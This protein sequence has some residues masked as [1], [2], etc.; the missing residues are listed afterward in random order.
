MYGFVCVFKC[1]SINISNGYGYVRKKCVYMGICVLRNHL[2]PQ[3]FL[4]LAKVPLASTKPVP[5][6]HPFGDRRDRGIYLCLWSISFPVKQRSGPGLSLAG[7]RIA[8]IFLWYISKSI[9][10]YLVV[11]LR[12]IRAP[13]L[14]RT[15]VVCVNRWGPPWHILSKL[16]PTCPRFLKL[17]IPRFI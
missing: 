7:E 17:Y 14:M 9:L 16:P 11:T 1:F 12:N 13:I 3:I 8:P 10:K 5:F 4:S 15:M 6:L 2:S